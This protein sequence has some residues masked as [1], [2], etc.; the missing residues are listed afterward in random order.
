GTPMSRLD[1]LIRRSRRRAAEE[2]QRLADLTAPPK[3]MPELRRKVGGLWEEMGNHQFDFLVAQG[4]E[5]DDRLLDVGCGVLRGGRHFVRYLDAG[6]YCGIDIAA[7]MIDGAEQ[8]LVEDGLADKRARLR[9]TEEF[10]VD[11]GRPFDYAIAQSVFTHLP[12]NSIYRALANVSANLDEGGVFYATFFR[13]P[14]GP[15]RLMPIQQP[16]LEGRT[17]VRTVADRNH[18]HYSPQDFIRLCENLPLTVTDIGDWGHP[19]GQQMLALTRT[20]A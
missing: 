20:T 6:N 9:V 11:F 3:T 17:S 8:Q 14:D 19:R 13:G 12:M 4:L 5:P 15:E 16:C 1:M 7:E 2:V 10:D 18:Y